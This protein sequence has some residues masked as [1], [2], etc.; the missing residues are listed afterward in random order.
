MQ[1]PLVRNHTIQAIGLGLIP[2]LL[3]CL[4]IHQPPAKAASTTLSWDQNVESDLAGYKIYQ[5]TLP[6]FD[7]GSPIFSGLPS[8][9]SSPSR[10]ISGLN[11][12]T[13]Y[14]FITTAF[15]QSGNESGP[16]N[17]VIYSS[18][19]DPPPS[20]GRSFFI[21]FQPSTAAV[22]SGFQ[23]DH[24]A[25][26]SP[27]RGYG[28]DNQ[29]DTVIRNSHANPLLDTFI[30][31][32]SGNTATW[33]L[34]VPNGEYLISLSS[35]DPS[36]SQGPHQISLEGD[37]A[38]NDSTQSNEFISIEERPIEITD[39][40]LTIELTRSSSTK[41]LLNYLVLQ[42]MDSETIPLFVSTTGNGTVR[43]NPGDMTCSS[44]LC[45]EEFPQGT[46]VSLTATPA[47]GWTFQEWLGACTGSS[48]CQVTLNTSQQVIA[49]F[50]QGGSNTESL[51]VSLAGD[52][53]GTI[54]STPSGISCGGICTRNFNIGTNVTL[55]AS[56]ASG[57]VFAGWSGGGCSGTGSC[58]VILS[59][60]T[61][62]TAT[63]N[64]VQTN[65]T[66]PTILTPSPESP[67]TGSTANF[68]WTPK[69]TTVLKWWLHV[70]STQ[71]AFDLHD[72]GSLGSASRSATIRNLPTNGNPVWVRLWYQL[73]SSWQST[74]FQYAT[75]S[76]TP[77]TVPL[78]ITK[79]GTGQG[80]ITSTP[81]GLNCGSTCT[82]QFPTGTNLPVTLSA[83]AGSNS[84]FAGWSGGGCSDTGSCTVILSQ[85]TAVTATFNLVQTNSTDPTILTPSPELPLTGS[86]ASFTWTPKTTT[87]LKWW[88]HVGSTQGAFDLHDT[89]SLGSA[90]RSTTIRNLPTNGNPVWVRLW[91]QLASSWQSTDF[92]YATGSTTPTTVPLTITKNGTGQGT[93][94]S[95]PVGLNCGSTC[96][97]QFS[98]NTD[99]PVS[100]SATAGANSVFARWSGGG[101]SGTGSC[102]VT[103]SQATT[104]TATFNLSQ[105]IPTDP[106][107]RTPSPGSPL[108]GSTVT[109]TWETNG[110]PVTEWWVYVGN[111]QGAKN[112]YN[113][114][115]LSSNILSRSVTGLPSNGSPIWVKLWWRTATTDWESSDI[116]Y[117]GNN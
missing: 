77:T 21:N 36:Q 53:N 22:P 50:T 47:S 49:L 66:D 101:C 97:A 102:T 11:A 80:T 105:S 103:L 76:T 14:G 43:S 83:T 42:P 18:E 94:T 40:Q 10:T 73:A 45:E 87:V 106:T 74:D 32:D 30:F 4:L 16:S 19:I 96:T 88:L 57:S 20:S 71:G 95:T 113:S 6:L 31:F 51:A 84:V 2:V 60:A 3:L 63:F 56:A 61:A 59:Q 35:G 41:T 33:E 62:V 91:Y 48:S 99:E 89:G 55:S 82:A 39:G 68:T 13:E 46:T 1:K 112:I 81:A 26:Y 34:D 90:S 8:N 52:G 98:T 7:F 109:F 70:G 5:R 92:Q 86:T 17:E 115:S 54:T 24:G 28:W 75:G 37:P 100:L 67:L 15:D 9:A 93:I 104:V 79:S 65:S 12:D 110:T 78:T 111:S 107:I 64:L 58:T 72:T 25:L 116:R 27:S 117:T 29:I 23:A 114:G 108:T 69:T 85:A 38:V 44:R